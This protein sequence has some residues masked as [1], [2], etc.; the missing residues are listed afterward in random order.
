MPNPQQT[1]SNPS[2]TRRTL[3]P[4]ARWYIAACITLTAA[5]AA[6]N[7]A[8][9]PFQFYRAASF[10][11][12]VFSENQRYQ[13]PGLAKNYPYEIAIVGDSH[14][15]NFS[16]RYVEA[17][18]GAPA[19]NLAISGSTAREQFLIAKKAIESGRLTRII[20]ILGRMPFRKPPQMLVHQDGEF[21]THFYDESPTTHPAY[22]LSIATL[23]LSLDALRGAGHRDLDSLDMWHSEHEFSQQRMLMDWKR[24]FQIYTTVRRDPAL[25]Y[26]SEL[27]VIR[28]NAEQNLASLIAAHPEI[29]VDLVFPP[30]SVLSYLIDFRM[31]PFMFKE[32]IQYKAMVV[33]SVAGLDNADVYDF[34][35]AREITHDFD[36]Y[37]DLEHFRV[38]INERIVDAIAAGEYRVDKADYSDV[39]SDFSRQVTAF[40][41]RVCGAKDDSRLLCPDYTEGRPRDHTS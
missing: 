19:L 9:D 4:Y 29:Q 24:R 2:G 28:A 31:A 30:Y 11:E 8:I 35:V 38:E 39:L 33:D 37:K 34:Q 26:Q 17:K 1:D 6:V 21:P 16:A 14:A 22:L 20:W 36:N 40:R 5:I 10:Y 3:G 23:E 25:A 13:K 7:F 18:L 32:R 41:K 15:E 27:D 12:P